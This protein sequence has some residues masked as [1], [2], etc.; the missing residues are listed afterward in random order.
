MSF[1]KLLTCYGFQ[2]RLAEGCYKTTMWYYLKITI[3]NKK[4]MFFWNH[5]KQAKK[6]VFF[7]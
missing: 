1:F 4:T 3:K 6:N 5:K 7:F 2:D